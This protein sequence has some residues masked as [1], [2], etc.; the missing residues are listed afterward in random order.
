MKYK[1]KKN[2]AGQ[3]M[4]EHLVVMLGLLAGSAGIAMLA[5][6]D[7][8]IHRTMLEGESGISATDNINKTSVVEA[9]NIHE[10]NFKDNMMA[11]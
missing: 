8:D 3:M 1:N 5:A 10:K 6:S 9:I 4:V 7:N 11:P 2:H